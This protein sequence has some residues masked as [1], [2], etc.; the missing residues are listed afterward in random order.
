M[1]PKDYEDIVFNIIGAAQRVH[2]EMNWGLME[3]LYTESLHLE[4]EMRG[5]SSEMEKPLPCY[6]RGIKLDKGY[7]PDLSVGDVM[8]ELKSCMKIIP[9]H[10]AQLFNYMRLTRSPIGLI[11]NFGAPNLQGE[12]YAWL[13][14]TNECILLDRHMNMLHA[15]D[16]GPTEEDAERFMMES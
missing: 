6:Y 9:A 8:V 10:R 14:E 4:L 5:I 7:Q 13:A 11:I 3:A 12:R 2:S 1:N 16:S 15:V